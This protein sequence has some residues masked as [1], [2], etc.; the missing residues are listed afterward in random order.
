MKPSSSFGRR[1]RER[2]ES[3]SSE[4]SQP[5]ELKPSSSFGRKKDSKLSK[6][7][8]SLSWNTRK[9]REGGGP[10][11]AIEALG[12]AGGD[13]GEES[14]T[15]EISLAERTAAR[16]LEVD[17]GALAAATHGESHPHRTWSF[18]RR[19]KRNKDLA[20]AAAPEG[21]T[22]VYF[23]D[24]SHKLF[25]IAPEMLVG[26]LLQSVKARLGVDASNSFALYQVP[27]ARTPPAPAP[28]A[29]RALP[30]LPRALHPPRPLRDDTQVQRGQH[31]L[32]HEEAALA[33]L[34][35]ASE[36]R[37]ASLGN[38]K[39]KVSR[40][41]PRPSIAPPPSPPAPH[42]VPPSCAGAEA[43]LQEVPLLQTRRAPHLREGLHSSLLHPGAPPPAPPHTP[44]PTH[45]PPPALGPHRRPPSSPR[46]R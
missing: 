21:S 45:T 32:L 43:A 18:G 19:Q 20:E 7:S 26:E 41:P 1:P 15:R 25:D 35:S 34:R 40:L 17:G 27:R 37:K 31:F 10:A 44:R 42:P 24:G 6:I 28:A 3:Q 4:A 33:E 14:V 46:R 29:P 36:S 22:R 11:E 2:S 38:K 23:L 13:L 16:G 39:E 30:S 5:G 9:K 12:E 8:R